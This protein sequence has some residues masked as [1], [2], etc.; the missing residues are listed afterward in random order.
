MKK[1]AWLNPNISLSWIR[2]LE[3]MSTNIPEFTKKDNIECYALICEH[4]ENSIEQERNITYVFLKKNQSVEAWINVIVKLNPDI[5]FYNVFPGSLGIQ[6]SKYFKLNHTI[7]VRQIM[8]LHTEPKIAFRNSPE[9]LK[10]VDEVICSVSTQQKFIKNAGFVG[11]IHTISFGVDVEFFKYNQPPSHGN[12]NSNQNSDQNSDQ[13]KKDI[14]FISSVDGNRTF[15]NAEL[16]KE[17]FVELEKLG[18]TTKN[19]LGCSKEQ[20]RNIFY[21]AKVIYNPSLIEASGG[22]TLLEAM[23]CGVVPIV[24]S[25]SET[26]CYIIKRLADGDRHI[27]NSGSIY[28]NYKQL[29]YSKEKIPEIVRKL[30]EIV[31][32]INKNPPG[33]CYRPRMNVLKNEYSYISEIDSIINV[34]IN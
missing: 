16:V 17:V 30:I 13:N 10:Y 27:T 3:K 31:E 26:C 25:E 22:R 7:P 9:M 28:N 2:A 24:D 11:K 4:D 19:V 5:I 15:K 34:L 23:S 14:D 18:Y 20:L 8:R 6:L 1:S 29:G 33:V 21:R 32:E 12:Q